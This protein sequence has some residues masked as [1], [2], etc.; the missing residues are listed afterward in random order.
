LLNYTGSSPGLG[1]LRRPRNFTIGNKLPSEDSLA[2]CHWQFSPPASASQTRRGCPTAP[3]PDEQGYYIR[4][5]C[6]NLVP[7]RLL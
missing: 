1:H 4:N 5:E 3:I 6:Y 7:A 2:N